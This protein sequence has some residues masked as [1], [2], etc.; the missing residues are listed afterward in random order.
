MK[1]YLREAFRAMGSLTEDVF[2]MDKEGAED[3]KRFEDGHVADDSFSIID[4][5][6]ADEEELAPSYVG[7]L[8]LD[9]CVCH[10]KIFNDKDDV[11]L[12]E[13]K[14]LANVGREC[15]F[16]Y[17]TDG[18]KIIGEV[19]P[20]EE[21]GK[22]EVK[23]KIDG[24]EAE[25]EEKESE[26]IEE[27]LFD[28]FKLKPE[29]VPGAFKNAVGKGLKIDPKTGALS[30]TKY[31][32]AWDP[33]V[34][35][36]LLGE[37]HTQ[38]QNPG[39]G[40][41]KVKISLQHKP[42]MFRND[43]DVQQTKAV[44]YAGW[45]EGR[46]RN[47]INEYVPDR[48]ED[49]IFVDNE[50]VGKDGKLSTTAMREWKKKLEARHGLK[51]SMEEVTVRTEDQTIHVSAEPHEEVEEKVE[52]VEEVAAPV[53]EETE[54][55]VEIA[56]DEATG[57]DEESIEE[58][59]EESFDE[60]GEAY[61]KKAYNNVKSFKTTSATISEGKLCLEGVIGFASGKNKATSFVFESLDIAD[62]GKARLI[63]GNTELA[64]GRKAFS[65]YGN[66]AGK[67]FIAE[68]LNFNYR[69]RDVSTGKPA[70]VCGTVSRRK[71]K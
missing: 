19:A 36:A 1:S 44:N 2:P 61:L 34:G 18:F 67:K 64:S 48:I 51:E 14:A 40:D 10:S 46:V 41:Y 11:I 6:A 25:V 68:S 54:E 65:V 22:T 35:H 8:I 13:D 3:L 66:V 52:E 31:F 58:V 24:D 55:E 23:V 39:Q 5:R 17:S 59:D 57:E 26:K 28:K 43:F 20:V 42:D 21:E 30:F 53:S 60:L 7:K 63:G 69:T 32:I 56:S 50:D 33:K 4:M 16:C 9:C 45:D 47:I 70:R 38:E 49:F 29:D 15:P 62:T 12:S 37:V 71:R 27:G